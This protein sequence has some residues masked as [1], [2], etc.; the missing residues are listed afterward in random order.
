M[1][2]AFF[3]STDM[4]VFNFFAK[5][6]QKSFFNLVYKVF[7]NLMQRFENM[8]IFKTIAIKKNLTEREKLGFLNSSSNNFTHI[9]EFGRNYD[10]YLSN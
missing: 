1:S 9:G 6:S 3:K 10:V 7:E 8:P 4:N 2:K 5:Y